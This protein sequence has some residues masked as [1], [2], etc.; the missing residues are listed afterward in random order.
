MNKT[1]A[2][3]E[4]AIFVRVVERGG[5]AAAAEETGLTPSGISKAVTRLEDRLG[6]KLL[7]RT[8]RRLMLTAEGETL[9]V[10]GREILAAIEATEAEVMAARGKPRGTIRVNMG[11][12]YAKHRM[13]PVLPE[14]RARYPEIDLVVSVADRRIDVIGEQV[15]VAIR[16]G[17][18]TD[19]SLVARRLGEARRVIA[20]SPAYLA[21]HGAPEQASDL[22]RHTCLAISGLARLSEWPLTV[23]GRVTSVPIKPAVTC[24]NADILAE[25]ALAGLGIVR[26]ASFVIEDALA[27]GRLVALLTDSHVSEAVPITALMPPGRQHLPRVRAFVDFLVETAPRRLQG[28]PETVDG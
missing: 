13:A 28:A 9:L 3:D 15:D 19:S 18:L 7:Q 6:V 17:P 24:D 25:M 12:A 4:I 23:D 22:A 10:R 14:F 27:D 16:T 26:L 5:F 21:R 2:S 1:A 8:T 11:T 20:A